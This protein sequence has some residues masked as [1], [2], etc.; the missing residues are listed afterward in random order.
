M[1]MVNSRKII[2]LSKIWIHLS[3]NLKKNTNKIIWLMGFI[4][5]WNCVFVAVEERAKV[6]SL[7][8]TLFT[9]NLVCQDW[10]YNQTYMC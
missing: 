5:H 9:L 3:A 2:L 7:R 8:N 1:N 6:I 10:C 4:N